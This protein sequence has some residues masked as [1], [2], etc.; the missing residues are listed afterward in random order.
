MRAFLLGAL[1]ALLMLPGAP[2]QAQDRDVDMDIFYEE[3]AP[4]GDW[5]EHPRWGLVW[6]PQVD[7]DWRPYSL[8]YWTFTDDYGWYWVSDEPFGWA[9]FHYGRWVDDEDDGW[10]WIPGT[11]WAPAWVVWRWSDDDEYVGWA[12]LGP[13]SS[14]DPDGELRYDL[15]YYESPAYLYAWCFVSPRYLTVPGLRRHLASRNEYARIFRRTHHVQAYRRHDRRVVNSGIDIRRFERLTGHPVAR[16]RLKTVD[17]PRDLRAHRERDTE[18][19]VFMP[20]IISRPDG[21]K[22]LPQLKARPERK[23]TRPSATGLPQGP[24]GAPLKKDGVTGPLPKIIPAPSDGQPRFKQTPTPPP[25]DGK[26]PPAE[27]HKELKRVP[28]PGPTRTEPDALRKSGPP[29]G[30][31]GQP[32]FKGQDVR[33][34]VAPRVQQVPRQETRQAPTGAPP[35]P[36]GPPPQRK[37]D[38]DKDKDK[39]GPD[40]R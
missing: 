35:Q 5:F 7:Q 9:V 32:T 29:S 22:R 38:K 10:I 6:Q 3:L 37:D 30:T 1:L 26:G 40:V 11:E 39:K 20:R 21:P 16:M 31:S 24:S 18:L 25:T 19:Q 13:G 4:Y 15:S 27:I 8:G 12:A 36:K 2:A 23:G 33:P 17:S 14:W 28:P 34:D